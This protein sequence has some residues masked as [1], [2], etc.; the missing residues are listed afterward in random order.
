MCLH[1]VEVQIDPVGSDYRRDMEPFTEIILGDSVVGVPGQRLAPDEAQFSVDQLK[2][3]YS[4]GIAE[5][6]KLMGSG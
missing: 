4:G 5:R 6:Q 3:R 2:R 1:T